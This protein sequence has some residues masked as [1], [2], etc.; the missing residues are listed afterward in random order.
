[1]C[2]AIFTNSPPP[3]PSPLSAVSQR[4]LR[5]PLLSP[6]CF[7]SL[8]LSLPPPHA[9]QPEKNPPPPTPD[10]RSSPLHI[11]TSIHLIRFVPKPTEFFSSFFFLLYFLSLSLS[12]S[13]F[14]PLAPFPSIT[15]TPA[16]LLLL[17]RTTRRVSR[18]KKSTQGK[19]NYQIAK[20]NKQTNNIPPPPNFLSPPPSATVSLQVNIL[21][22]SAG[23]LS[24]LSGGG[25]GVRGRG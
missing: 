24:L 22:Y 15:T 12:L 14:P 21:C 20:T 5:S 1:M 19:K 17:Q 10:I 3:P 23:S 18:R 6:W 4:L 16:P 8:S 25:G 9:T 2:G 7:A 13:F 11:A